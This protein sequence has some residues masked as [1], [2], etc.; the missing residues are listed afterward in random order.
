MRCIRPQKLRI[1][2]AVLVIG[3][4]ARAAIGGLAYPDPPGGW[5]YIYT[6]DA[7]SGGANYTALDGAWSHNN[8][9]DQWDESA[10]GTGRPGGASGITDGGKGSF[11]VRQSSDDDIISFTLANV[12]ND[13]LATEKMKYDPTILFTNVGGQEGL[14]MNCLTTGGDNDDEDPWEYDGD[15]EVLNQV[16]LAVTDWHEFSITIEADTSGGGTH[17]VK[18]RVDGAQEAHEFHLTAGGDNDY[19]DS[20]IAM[21]LGATGAMGAIDV[22]FFAY[23]PGTYES[24]GGIINNPPTV[25]AGDDQIKWLRSSS[26]TVR[27]N[28]E[29][30]DDGIGDPDGYLAMEWQW[31]GGTGEGPILFSPGNNIEDPNITI[32]DF[33]TYELQLEATDGRKTGS[34]TVTITINEG[35]KGDLFV[36]NKVDWKD[37][38][39]FTRMWL[40]EPPS[41]ADLVGN[42]RVNV[43]DYAVLANNW[44][45]QTYTALVEI[46]EFMADNEDTLLTIYEPGGEQHSPDWIEIHNLDVNTVDLTGWYVTDDKDEPDK[47]QLPDG[48]IIEGGG[49][50]IVFASGLGDSINQFIDP[51]GYYHT[52]FQLDKGGDYLALVAP[53]SLKIIHEFADYEYDN[54]KF[55]FPP[56]EE[57]Y[58][59]GILDA[60]KR[61]FSAPTPETENQGAFEGFVADTK[62]SHD[63]GFYDTD[64]FVRITTDTIGAKIRYTTDGSAPTDSHGQVYDPD[65]PIG[66]TTTTTLRAAAFKAGWMPTNID[67]HTY[68][69]PDH[70]LAQPVLPAGYPAKWGSIDGDYQVDPDIVNHSDPCDRLHPSDLRCVPT[71]SLV[72]DYDDLFGSNQIYLYGDGQERVCSIEL[73]YPDGTTGF[74]ENGIVQIQGGSSTSRWK[75]KKLS[76]RYKFKE[77]MKNGTP[78]GGPRKLNHQLYPDATIDRYDN[79]IFD[80]VLNNSWSHG[81]RSTQRRNC[82]FIQDQYVSDLH[83]AMGGNSPRGLFAHLYLNGLYWGMYYVHDRPDHAW[84]E[85]MFG[86]Y[87]DQYHALKHNKVLINNGNGNSAVSNYDAM[88][89]AATNAGNNPTNLAIWDTLC[90]NLDVDNLITYLLAHWFPGTSDWAGS[91]GKNVYYT[92][93]DAPDGRWRH[94]TWDAEHTMKDSDVG[95]ENSPH[96]IHNKLKNNVEY[97]MRFADLVHRFFFN[98]GVLSGLNPYNMYQARMTE[99]DRA[100]VGESAR[101]GDAWDHPPYTRSDWL[102][103]QAG[104]LGWLDNRPTYVLNDLL[105]PAGLY[106]NLDAPEFSPHGGWD[107]DG[108][109]LTMTKPA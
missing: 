5:T 19:D 25:N 31:V 41:D 27:L 63:R 62:F 50:R 67:T 87:K 61:Y 60:T 48:F 37:L 24:A 80:A 84:A 53:G 82:M 73:V 81:T 23:K 6:G 92:C 3:V 4:S 12:G 78:T 34:D 69:F 89:T 109:T 104:K 94:H 100:I 71:F 58:S 72:M 35:L 33:G 13:P 26:I 86:G 54:N 7:T 40:D 76:M 68:I 51:Y 83:N 107:L 9:S 22:D 10:I 74:Q 36:D 79:I 52:S 49:Y 99:I 95:F 2:V 30:S 103:V 105:K 1:L 14:V 64:F 93:R 85:E 32:Y 98:H 39:L 102:N 29:V 70:V 88:L 90:Q 66:I 15:G 101:W 59:Y 45:Y 55:G 20:Y 18:V 46:S 16:A 91:S 57:D 56:Q 38:M 42:D 11:S 44:W 28:G 21:G 77:C 8:G 43:I 75:S 47:W 106:P 108:F 96:Y 17:L 65:N 97:K